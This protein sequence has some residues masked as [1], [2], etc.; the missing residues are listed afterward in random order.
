MFAFPLRQKIISPRAQ[1]L[2]QVEKQV[3]QLLRQVFQ[4]KFQVRTLSHDVLAMGS[5]W[6]EHAA[7]FSWLTRCWQV[8]GDLYNHTMHFPSI[9]WSIRMSFVHVKSCSLSP[10]L[11][12]VNELRAS[13]SNIL[14]LTYATHNRI[15]IKRVA[16]RLTILTILSNGWSIMQACC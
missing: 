1:L 12:I 6:R 16:F 3:C 9:W 15:P 10:L 2:K 13:T 5:Y 11:R 4:F 7:L 14:T 8:G